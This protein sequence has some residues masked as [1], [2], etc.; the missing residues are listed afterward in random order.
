MHDK[1]TRPVPCI[2]GGVSSLPSTCVDPGATHLTP[3][4][5]VSQHYLA[6]IMSPQKAE[7]QLVINLSAGV[8]PEKIKTLVE[9]GAQ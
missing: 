7:R 2:Q 9:S 3:T 8:M 5:S 6:K 4:N 1:T